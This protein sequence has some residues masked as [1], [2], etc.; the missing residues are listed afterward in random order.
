MSASRSSQDLAEEIIRRLDELKGRM[1]LYQDK[2]RK[3]MTEDDSSRQSG[4]S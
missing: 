1:E 4:Q 2:V 3:L